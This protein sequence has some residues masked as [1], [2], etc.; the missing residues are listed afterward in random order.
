MVQKSYLP[1]TNH[2]AM[3]LLPQQEILA[4]GRLGGIFCVYHRAQLREKSSIQN[5]K[6]MNHV[7]GA[8][9][10]RVIESPY[11]SHTYTIG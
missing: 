9:T 8:G 10:F 6:V 7:V 2:S 4:G 5:V 11:V 3:R 1:Y